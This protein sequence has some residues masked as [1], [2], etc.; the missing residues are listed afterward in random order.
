MSTVTQDAPA[1]TTIE[2]TCNVLGLANAL[3]KIK[4]VCPTRSPKPILQNVRLIVDPEKGS[5]LEATD[6]EIGI[7]V[8][9]LG[10]TAPRAVTLILPPIRLDQI[11]QGAV[12]R[13]DTLVIAVT[14]SGS[15][16]SA[17]IRLVAASGK[18]STFHL[19]LESAENFPDVPRFPE[20]G[21]YLQITSEDLKKLITRTIF[22]TDLEATRYALGGCL[23]TVGKEESG[24]DTVSLVAT[25]GRRLAKQSVEAEFLDSWKPPTK[26]PVIPAKALKLVAKLAAPDVSTVAITFDADKAILFKL[27]RATIYSRLVE[28]RFPKYQDIFPTSCNG[29]ASCTVNELLWA[30]QQA[31]IMT[32][33][34]SRGIDYRFE[35]LLGCTVN[36]SASEKGDGEIEATLDYA[37]PTITITFCG[38]YLIEAL[39]T[40]NRMDGVVLSLVDKNSPAVLTLAGAN[41]E[42]TYVVMP[43][44]RDL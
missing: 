38:A 28:G 43:L 1:A 26:E 37:G 41:G 29:K 9:V 10:I 44:T 15:G 11:L 39:Q 14:D 12:G 40:L 3:G 6:L 42:Y 4:S 23:F 17:E 19:P 35:R 7:S 16:P 25:D 8:S 13:A 27:D 36:A 18:K 2:I 33:E 5:L 30:T 20:S 34:D 24:R 22:A 21:P 32:S 31:S